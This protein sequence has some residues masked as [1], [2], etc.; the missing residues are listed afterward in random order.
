MYYDKEAYAEVVYFRVKN[1]ILRKKTE[2]EKN[3]VPPIDDVELNHL[4]KVEKRENSAIVKVIE[5]KE[6]CVLIT[7]S[8]NTYIATL[9]N[10]IEI[11]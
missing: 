4:Y 11:Q 5:I 3:R 2:D 1:V 10:T 6:K 7:L 9:L 8:D